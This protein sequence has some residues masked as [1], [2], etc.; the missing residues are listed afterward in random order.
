MTLFIDLGC[1]SCKE[2]QRAFNIFKNTL[3]WL[4]IDSVDQKFNWLECGNFSQDA[5]TQWHWESHC[6]FTAGGERVKSSLRFQQLNTLLTNT[7]RN[8]FQQT[9]YKIHIGTN[10]IIQFS[11]RHT[12]KFASMTFLAVIASFVH[13]S[14]LLLFSFTKNHYIQEDYQLD[15]K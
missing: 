6:V 11:R 10:L 8:P 9:H 7:L 5:G 3:N 4:K 2:T 1:I 13:F 12:F 15:T 14:A